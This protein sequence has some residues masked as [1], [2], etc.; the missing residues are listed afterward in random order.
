MRFRGAGLL[1]RLPAGE[2]CLEDWAL[3]VR[4]CRVTRVALTGGSWSLVAAAVVGIELLLEAFREWGRLWGDWGRE[5]AASRVRFQEDSWSPLVG[6]VGAGIVVLDA[7]DVPDVR[8]A[9]D[10][11]T[12]VD[13]ASE[14]CP[15]PSRAL[16]M[17][18]SFIG[19]S[20]S[21]SELSAVVDG[22]PRSASLADVRLPMEAC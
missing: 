14:P 21:S 10:A 20:T 5:E 11:A 19:L 8:R 17:A 7:V 15:P 2:D 13:D 12:P 4:A 18:L 3:P 6:L 22:W 9:A 1:S 16:V